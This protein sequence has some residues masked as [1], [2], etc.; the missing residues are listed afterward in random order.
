M[1]SPERASARLGDDAEPVATLDRDVQ[2]AVVEPIDHVDH[3]GARPDAAHPVVVLE[4]EAEL[5]IVVEAV[6]DQIL[7]AR[8]EDVQRHPFGRDEH[9]PERK[10]T[11]LLRH[12]RSASVCIGRS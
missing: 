9:D 1:G 12:G 7:V 8:L 10:H 11:E 5:P 6:A 4:D 2:P 3:G